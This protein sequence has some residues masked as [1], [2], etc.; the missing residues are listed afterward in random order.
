MIKYRI[1]FYQYFSRYCCIMMCFFFHLG[2]YQATK[3]ED[4]MN[5]KELKKEKEIYEVPKLEIVEFELE[6]SIAASGNFGPD[7][8]CG[9]ELS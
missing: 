4:L 7:T 8:I 2:H 9:G 3:K 6:D 1:E 5:K